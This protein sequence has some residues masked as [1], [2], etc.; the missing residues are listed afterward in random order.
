MALRGVSGLDNIQRNLNREIAAIERRS[1]VGMRMA[2][3]LVLGQSKVYTPVDTS[4]LIGDTETDVFDSP[5]G[6]TGTIHYHASYAVF[7]HEIDK[8][9][10]GPKRVRRRGRWVI[11]PGKATAQWK[12]LQRALN[13]KHDEV[14]E[15]LAESAQIPP[16]VRR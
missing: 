10:S 5:N 12:Y 15:A 3:Y 9:Y 14:L 11:E 2:V 7:V 13:E 1:R 4:N 6:I 8:N 16:T